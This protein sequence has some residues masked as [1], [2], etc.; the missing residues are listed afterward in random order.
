MRFII[1]TH[2]SSSQNAFQY[3]RC[4]Y[5]GGLVHDTPQKRSG[6]NS[7]SMHFVRLPTI[8]VEEDENRAYCSRNGD[9]TILCIWRAG[10]QAGKGGDSP[11][12]HT[13]ACGPKRKASLHTLVSGQHVYL[14][15]S[16]SLTSG[17]SVLL[18]LAKKKCRPKRNATACQSRLPAKAGAICNLKNVDV[19]S[20]F[21]KN[22]Y[23]PVFSYSGTYKSRRYHR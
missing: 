5:E 23:V 12:T 14:C 7:S 11:P 4:L 13:H 9:S 2:R 15:L 10:R 6:S 17:T 8:E 3:E 21:K 18:P 16:A 1:R 19:L 20:R 22:L